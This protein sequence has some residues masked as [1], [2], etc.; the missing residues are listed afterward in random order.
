ML[1]RVTPTP[2]GNNLMKTRT[3]SGHL[4]HQVRGSY[5][6]AAADFGRVRDARRE[7]TR[8]GL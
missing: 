5:S 2:L 8:S 3:N 4:V 6:S 7:N 1:K